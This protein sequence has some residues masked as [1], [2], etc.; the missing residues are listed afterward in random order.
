MAKIL[1][2]GNEIGVVGYG[3]GGSSFEEV[4]HNGQV[5]T[6]SGG[7]AYMT[8]SFSDISAHKYAIVKLYANVSGVDYV[9]YYVVNI[10]DIISDTEVY[11]TINIH[12]PVEMA[13]TATTIRATRYGGNWEDIYADVAVSDTE[14]I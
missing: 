3:S 8:A 11:F 1:V 14:L 2:N 6:T 13:M 7:G 4:L 9:G 12:T 10:A 5:S